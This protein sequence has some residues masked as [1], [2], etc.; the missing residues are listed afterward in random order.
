MWWEY[1]AYRYITKGPD[2]FFGL[3]IYFECTVEL[4]MI[5]DAMHSQ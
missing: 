4:P 1:N 3:N 2:V 5:L